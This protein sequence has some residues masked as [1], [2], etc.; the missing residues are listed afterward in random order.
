M[1]QVGGH[2]HDISL[3]QLSR[4]ISS[5]S[6][7]N[8]GNEGPSSRDSILSDDGVENKL[9]SEF[10][11]RYGRGFKLTPRSRAGGAQGDEPIEGIKWCVTVNE[12]CI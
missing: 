3:Q 11:E 4:D 1:R 10:R 7:E 2:L 5:F 6:F 12:S 9:S 8:T